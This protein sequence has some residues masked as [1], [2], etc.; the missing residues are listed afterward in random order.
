[1]PLALLLAFQ[2]AGAPVW[3]VESN[4]SG[5][6]LGYELGR[7]GDFDGDGYD[8]VVL[9][10]SGCS[11]GEALEGL[12]WVFRG[13]STGLG[14]LPR[15]SFERDQASAYFGG[16]AAS[17]G[18]VNGDGFDDLIVGAPSTR[19]AVRPWGPRSSTWVRPR[20]SGP[21]PPRPSSAARRTGASVRAWRA[22][23]TS[24]ATVSMT[25]S[26]ARRSRAALAARTST[27]ASRPGS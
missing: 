3:S 13:S 23:A 25:S 10:L 15:W 19:R 14:A 11:Q 26:S 22:R 8:D 12:V 17:A 20:D 21:R 1:M 7:A 27:A 9:G 6:G 18:D 4:Q 2:L 5:C 16:S 24:T